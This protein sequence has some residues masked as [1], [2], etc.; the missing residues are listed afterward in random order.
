MSW[1][2]GDTG[3]GSSLLQESND[4]MSI[5][6]SPCTAKWTQW[7]TMR[8]VNQRTEWYYV[9]W[10]FDIANY[11]DCGITWNRHT[12]SFICIMSIMHFSFFVQHFPFGYLTPFHLNNSSI[13]LLSWGVFIH[14]TTSGVDHWTT[15]MSTSSHAD[16]FYWAPPP[17]WDG[18]SLLKPDPHMFITHSCSHN[19]T[20]NEH[21]TLQNLEATDMLPVTH[22]S[23]VMCHVIYFSSAQHGSLLALM[24]PKY[25]FFATFCPWVHTAA[26]GS[27]CCKKFPA[28]SPFSD[29]VAWLLYQQKSLHTKHNEETILWVH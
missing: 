17:H 28:D 9:L 12:N 15:G 14:W 4:A 11:F 25:Y 2:M 5:H 1:S 26:L 21:D 23:L 7:Q 6:H 10:M 20:K 13:S 19:T 3:I 16:N 27:L 18:T 22:T 24:Y 29:N 8:A